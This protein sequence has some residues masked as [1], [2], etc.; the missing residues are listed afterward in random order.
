MTPNSPSTGSVMKSGQAGVELRPGDRL[1]VTLVV[2]KKPIESK[3][4]PM[5]ID[6]VVR[7]WNA[8]ASPTVIVRQIELTHAAFE[9]S[10]DDIV[11]LREQGVSNRVI[12]AMQEPCAEALAVPPS[13]RRIPRATRNRL[14]INPH[15]PINQRKPSPLSGFRGR[16]AESSELDCRALIVCREGCASPVTHITPY[17][18]ANIQFVPDGASDGQWLPALAGHVWLVNDETGSR[19]QCDGCLNIEM[20]DVTTSTPAKLVEW[21]FD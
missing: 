15:A 16:L 17:W 10:T 20:Y 1:N 19:L 2:E 11:Y 18:H 6:D 13:F 12:S 14:S 3:C 4:E 9:L 5:S 7:L 8:G 21:R